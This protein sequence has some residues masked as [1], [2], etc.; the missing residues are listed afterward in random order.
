MMIIQLSCTFPFVLIHPIYDN[1]IAA[2][3]VLHIIYEYLYGRLFHSAI[4]ITDL[5]KSTNIY[6]DI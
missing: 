1:K 6:F 5:L 3:N 2:V 4:G